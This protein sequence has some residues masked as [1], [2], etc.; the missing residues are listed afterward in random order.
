MRPKRHPSSDVIDHPLFCHLAPGA[1][2]VASIEASARRDGRT[3]RGEDEENATPPAGPAAG[4][5]F[6][7]LRAALRLLPRVDSAAAYAALAARAVTFV[8]SA[9]RGR[10]GAPRLDPAVGALR[11]TGLFLRPHPVRARDD[12]DDGAAGLVPAIA[13]VANPSPKQ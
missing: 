1:A 4:G 13:I 2:V 3:A 10:A 8:T 12:A 7:A 9:W 11:N 6:A 5:C